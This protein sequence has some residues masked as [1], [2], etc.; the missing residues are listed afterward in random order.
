MSISTKT[1]DLQ[2]T[3]TGWAADLKG[4]KSDLDKSETDLERED[5]Q[6]VIDE[7]MD[8]SDDTRNDV[9]DTLTMEQKLQL[10]SKASQK[11]I[12]AAATPRVRPSV[13]PAV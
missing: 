13:F 3:Y 1:R 2:A 11:S 5:W 10:Q 8:L 6:A 9:V 12:A 4:R 7:G